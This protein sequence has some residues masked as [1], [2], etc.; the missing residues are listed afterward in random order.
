MYSLTLFSMFKCDFD[1]VLLCW[2]MALFIGVSAEV[3]LNLV[4][5]QLIFDS[6]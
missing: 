5:D 6:C 2:W 1:Y 3:K 4:L